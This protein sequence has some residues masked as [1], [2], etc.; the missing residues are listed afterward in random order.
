[1]SASMP[2][3]K[4]IKGGDR[5]TYRREFRLMPDTPWGHLRLFVYRRGDSD[6]DP[7]D[8]PWDFWTFPLSTYAE[9]VMGDDGLMTQNWVGRFRWH[10]RSAYYS[11]ILLGKLVRHW[12][13][14]AGVVGT[15]PFASLVWV[16]PNLHKWGFWVRQELVAETWPVELAGSILTHNPR[17]GGRVWVHWRTYL[18][19]R[20]RFNLPVAELMG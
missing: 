2:W 4:H 11:H 14:G 10:H 7:H 18:E 16:C 5:S 19:H 20:H 17:R 8:H 15:G 9:L 3:Y 1:M 12:W 13:L 6:P